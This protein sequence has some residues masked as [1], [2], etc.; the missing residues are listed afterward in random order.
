MK[1]EVLMSVMHQTDMSIG[2]KANVG[3]DLLIVNQ[4]DHDDYDEQVVDGHLWRMI[5]TTERGLAKSRNLAIRNAKGDICV[6]ADDDEVYEQDIWPEI[7]N[8]FDSLPDAT[9]IVYNVNRINY[10]MKKQYYRIENTRV[11]P[12][13]RG[14]GSVQLAFRLDV[15]RDCNILFN[16]KFGSGTEWGGGEDN[17]FQTD[18]RGKGKK[19]YEFP[20]CI[21]TIDYSNGSQWFHGYNEKYFYNL[22]AFEGYVNKGRIKIKSIARTIYICF[23]KLRKERNLTPFQK[24][25]WMYR[26][27]KGIQK[28][29]TYSQYMEQHK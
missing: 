23:Y 11:A 9:A 6:L 3:T 28:D 12:A 29:V 26:G 16:E 8:S 4:C 7:I 27:F 13:Y 22:G 25:L 20:L 18:I 15:I 1:V 17:L 21:A 2:Y 24:M 14:Y 19:I 5:S 10:K